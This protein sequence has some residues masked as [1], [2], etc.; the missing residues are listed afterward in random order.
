[1]MNLRPDCILTLML[2]PH[3]TLL[4]HHREKVGG[5]EEEKSKMLK[6]DR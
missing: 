6:P 2:G 1:M 5:G 4:S 3:E